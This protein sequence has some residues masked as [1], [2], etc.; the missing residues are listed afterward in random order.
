MRVALNL[1]NDMS[2]SKMK[3]NNALIEKVN[4]ANIT[5]DD[6]GS[7]TNKLYDFKFTKG[8]VLALT[9]YNGNDTKVIIPDKIGP[10]PVT[11]ISSNGWGGA[12]SGCSITDITI[13]NS[14]TKI[15]D[16]AFENN[17]ITNI[18]IPDSVTEIGDSAFNNNK[19]TSLVIPG[20]VKNIG[21]SAFSNN[22]LTNVTIENG[23]VTIGDNAFA[24]DHFEEGNNK[25]TSIII[26]ESV[27]NIGERTFFWNEITKI[28][29]GSNVKI[30][31]DS[32][33]NWPKY[34][35]PTD[36]WHFSEYDANGEKG[37][38]YTRAEGKTAWVYQGNK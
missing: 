17:K 35:W 38:I 25:L 2:A 21:D 15:D 23:V 12:F 29:I 8:G 1:G 16:Y 14:V 6:D 13:P 22:I 20:S 9:K 24:G 27:K 28:Q 30:S 10:W 32:F 33:G 3:N 36:G 31:D 37:G 7:G 11:A 4:F 26:P 19:L 18:I 34:P 5:I